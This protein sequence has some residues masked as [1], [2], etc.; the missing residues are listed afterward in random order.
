MSGR[1]NPTQTQESAKEMKKLGLTTIV[2]GA[3]MAFVA[4]GAFAGIGNGQPTPDQLASSQCVTQ[5][6][7]MGVKAFKGLYGKHAMKTCKNK[8]TP[9]ATNVVDNAAKQCKAEQADP[10]FATAHG[11]LT[12]DQTYGTNPNDKNAFGKCVSAK[13]QAPQAAIATQVQNAAQT[14]RAERADPAFA[15]AHG[16]KSFTDFYGTNHN[17]KNAFGKCV[18]GKAKAAPAPT[19]PPVS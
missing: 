5:Q 16:G 4:S 11:G 9:S 3:A 14:C 7:A 13:A 2:C 10:N 17:K 1:S 15:A 12:F 6:H 19:T 18:S 8:T